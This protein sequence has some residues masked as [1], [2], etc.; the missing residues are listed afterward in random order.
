MKLLSGLQQPGDQFRN[1][2]GIHSF[3]KVWLY[4]YLGAQNLAASQKPPSSNPDTLSCDSHVTSLSRVCFSPLQMHHDQSSPR[5]RPG[6]RGDLSCSGPSHCIPPSC[7]PQG[8]EGAFLCVDVMWSPPHSDPKPLLCIP[9]AL[10]GWCQTSYTAR[11]T[12]Q[13]HT[14]LEHLPFWQ[15]PAWTLPHRAWPPPSAWSSSTWLIT[16]TYLPDPGFSL[17][18]QEVCLMSLGLVALPSTMPLSAS[19]PRSQCLCSYL[20]LYCLSNYISLVLCMLAM[21]PLVAQPTVDAQEISVTQING[22]M[23]NWMNWNRSQGLTTN[24]AQNLCRSKSDWATRIL[25]RING[26]EW[27]GET[28]VAI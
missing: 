25:W 22:W 21:E 1:I 15:H 2:F 8:T 5:P 12:F 4:R 27:V 3:I 23:N 24:H 7:S 10:R 6:Y 14:H 20:I 28:E 11:R 19:G 18:R 17:A 9:A 26:Q 13:C 16:F